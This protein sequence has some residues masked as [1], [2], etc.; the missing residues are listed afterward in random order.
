MPGP[1][2]GSPVSLASAVNIA[3]GA[4]VTYEFST[5]QAYFAHIWA[6]ITTDSAATA[7]VTISIRSKTDTTANSG[8]A[9]STGLTK[10]VVATSSSVV[11]MGEHSAG[12]YDIVIT[13]ND[14]T[15]AATLNN[16]LYRIAN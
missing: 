13:N 4:T 11:D 7:G 14:G 9:A 8:L 5:G 16:L 6:D 15:Y 1:I 3:A 10:S 12:D 2:I